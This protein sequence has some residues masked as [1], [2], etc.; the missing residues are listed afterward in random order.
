M[1]SFKDEV[2]AVSVSNDNKFIISGSKDKSVKIFDAQE[3][4]EIY[5]FTDLHAGTLMA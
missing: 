4:S 5:H 1:N 3:K 2:S